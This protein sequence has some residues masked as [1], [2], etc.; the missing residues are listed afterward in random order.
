MILKLILE[1]Y[2]D[3][4]HSRASTI[5]L[6]KIFDLDK[7]Y[8]KFSWEWTQLEQTNSKKLRNAG[9]WYHHFNVRHGYTNHGEV[10]GA[11]NWSW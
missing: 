9:S 2:L 8:L 1:I 7:S 4:D 10:I 5:G 3:S 11:R 6:N